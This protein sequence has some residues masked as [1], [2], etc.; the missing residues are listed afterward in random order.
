V[1]TSALTKRRRRREPVAFGLRIVL[2]FVYGLPLL[3]IVLTSLK[4]QGEVLNSQASLFFTPTLE[5]YLEAFRDPALGDSMRQSIVISVGTTLICLALATPAAYALARVRGRIIMVA[6]AILVILQMI[7]QTANLIPLFWILAR[8]GLL[9]TDLG[10]VLADAT[11]F[12]PWAILLLRPFFAAIPISIEEASRIDGAGSLRAFL[13][14]ALPLAR[15]GVLTVTA[16]IFLVSWGE[17]LYGITFM[18]TPSKYPMSALIAV[19]AGA[20]GIDW[21]GMM[22]FA[23]ISAIPVFLVYVFSYRLLR[24]GL[25]MGAVK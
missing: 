3:W 1:T 20:Y 23:V 10:L 16:I 5:A 24:T 22:A 21:P 13:G 14:V 17:F 15:N 4:S 2:W 6:L 12:L 25:T 19:Q 18:L 8:L 11:L 7:P 9:N